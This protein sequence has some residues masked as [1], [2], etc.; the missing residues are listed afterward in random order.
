MGLKERD[1]IKEY[2]DFYL[3]QQGYKNTSPYRQLS[4]DGEAQRKMLFEREGQKILLFV[5]AQRDYK[6]G[7]DDFM[8]SMQE[9]SKA[10]IASLSVFDQKEFYQRDENKRLRVGG[11]DKNRRKLLGLE[12]A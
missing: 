7:L 2:L 12:M 10:R 3:E 8:R 5:H 6:G 11:T 1:A 9:A 4:G